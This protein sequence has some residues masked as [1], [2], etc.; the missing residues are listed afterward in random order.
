[1][2]LAGG[3]GCWV[4][5]FDRQWPNLDLIAADFNDSPSITIGRT[6]A[7]SP[8]VAHLGVGG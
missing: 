2:F 8:T 5:G 7:T 4:A 6:V 1:M 3:E